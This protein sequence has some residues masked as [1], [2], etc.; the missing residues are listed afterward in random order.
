MGRRL[1]AALHL[2]ILPRS[3]RSE[4]ERM[5]TNMRSRA[6]I[7]DDRGFGLIEIVI[8]MFLLALL[9]IA[10]LPLLI[11]SMNVAVTNSTTAT[12][13]Q[14]VSQQLDQVRGL[15]P[16]CAAVS[17]FDNAPVATTTDSRGTE[18]RPHRVVDPCPGTY[19]G[20][21]KVES[22]VTEEGKPE[23]LARAVTLV[24]L[25]TA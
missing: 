15:E 14:L 9:A 12:A 6:E 13:S 23:K 25:R 7:A 3:L 2:A 22:W 4:M 19:P 24:Y 10:F 1:K 20:V 21:I 8:S 18:Y 17:A 16:T 11:T 5:A